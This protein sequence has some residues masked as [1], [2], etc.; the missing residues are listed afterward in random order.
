MRPPLSTVVPVPCGQRTAPGV[1]RTVRTCPEALTCAFGGENGQWRT[2]PR[3]GTLA[4]REGAQ[5]T[6]GKNPGEAVEAEFAAQFA[7]QL[8]ALREQA[9][10]PSFRQMARI[11]HY[12][13]STL[14]EATAGKRLPTEPVVKAFV[15]A[16]GE[17]PAEWIARLRQ[18]DAQVRLAVAPPTPAAVPPAQPDAQAPPRRRP[19]LPR[20]VVLAAGT[21]GLLAIGGTAGALI[22]TGTSGPGPAQSLLGPVP[23][24]TV[25]SS[26]PSGDGEDPVV[27]RCA[28]DAVLVDKSALMVGGKQIGALEL[29]YSPHCGTGWAR[30]Y[31]YQGQ[32]SMMAQVDVRSADGRASMLAEAMIDTTPVYTDAIVPGAGGC[33]GADAEAFSP[34][35]PP[36][37]ASITCQVMPK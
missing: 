30:V 7:A 34:G 19:G 13:S 5:A 32:H 25:P 17:D 21:V 33:L 22:R 10:S 9:G 16:C 3:G 15:T 2:A 35:A 24:S 29:K 4:W 12:S 6:D 8:R 31:L 1:H 20:T 11:T 18:A 27:A 23:F 28:P 14:A 37:S 26:V 36:I